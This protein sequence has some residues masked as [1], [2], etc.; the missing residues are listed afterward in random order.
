MKHQRWKIRFV[1]LF[2]FKVCIGCM[3]KWRASVAKSKERETC[4]TNEWKIELILLNLMQFETLFLDKHSLTPE[5][6]TKMNM[7]R[8]DRP[9]YIVSMRYSE[10]LWPDGSSFCWRKTFIIRHLC[11]A[12]YLT[13]TKKGWHISSASTIKMFQWLFSFSI[14]SRSIIGSS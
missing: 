6:K 14:F 11:G 2:L 5:L 8:W 3:N 4:E 7:K 10:W 12:M 1:I 13:H 9:N